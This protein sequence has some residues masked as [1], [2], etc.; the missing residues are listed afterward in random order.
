MRNK[1]LKILTLTSMIIMTGCNKSNVETKP[2]VRSNY[3]HNYSFQLNQLHQ[4]DFDGNGEL[5][6]ICEIGDQKSGFYI[7]HNPESSFKH[8]TEENPFRGR[9]MSK[10]EVN[11]L[12]KIADSFT[13][14][15]FVRD[16]TIYSQRH[17]AN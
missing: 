5:I 14:Y 10:E 7:A 17:P 8:I 4:S 2:P 3:Q 1:L 12:H 9:E 6:G 13:N 15:R 11:A 16:S